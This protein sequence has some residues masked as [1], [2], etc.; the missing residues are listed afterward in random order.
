[1]KQDEQKTSEQDAE[2][3]RH[4]Q[5]DAASRDYKRQREGGFKKKDA[6]KPKQSPP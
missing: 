2:N 1:M 6:E 4:E 3:T 5:E